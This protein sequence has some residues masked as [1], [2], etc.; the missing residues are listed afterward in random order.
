[1]FNTKLQLKTHRSSNSVIA[2]RPV[3][4]AIDAI[5]SQHFR[6]I[7]QS[8]LN[9]SSS[10]IHFTTDISNRAQRP[11]SLSQPCRRS[12]LSVYNSSTPSL[13]IPGR[14]SS[15]ARAFNFKAQPDLPYAITPVLQGKKQ[16]K[17]RDE[18]RR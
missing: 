18:M 9:Q 5:T 13:L 7:N 11:A 15:L 12:F 1:M 14:S 10:M 2:Q 4:H 6:C 3:H 8:K 16:E 17:K